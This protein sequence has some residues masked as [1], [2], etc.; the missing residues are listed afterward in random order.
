MFTSAIVASLFAGLAA[1]A[2]GFQLKRTGCDVSY[3]VPDLPSG[4]TMLTV[5]AGEKPFT[6]GLG[7]GIRTSNSFLLG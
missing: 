2:S 6:I 5:P 7:I 1:S 3:A 4:Q